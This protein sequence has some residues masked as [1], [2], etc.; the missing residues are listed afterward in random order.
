MSATSRFNDDRFRKTAWP[1]LLAGTLMA[2][3]VGLSGCNSESAPYVVAP[4]PV[5]AAS[6]ALSAATET[7]TYSGT[8]KPRYESDLGFRVGGKIV[9]RLVNIGDTVAPGT[10]LARLDA[11]DYRLSHESPRRSSRPR[12]AASSRQKPTSSAMRISIGSPGSATRATIRRRRRQTR[13]ADAQSGP[14]APCHWRRISSTIPIC[15]PRNP[16]SLQRFRS[17]S[18]RWSRPGN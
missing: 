5:R 8:I 4:Q 16:A 3:A 1:L 10:T 2:A 12:K 9:E 17:K 18:G 15:R 11:T 13:R 14:S 7:R 6:V